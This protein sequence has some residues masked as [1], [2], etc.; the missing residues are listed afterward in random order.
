[1]K[2]LLS[3]SILLF[4]FSCKKSVDVPNPAFDVTVE[5]NTFRV[6]DTIEFKFTGSANIITFYSGEP[7][8]EYQFRERFE[9]DGKPQM[10]FTSYSQFG[11]QSNSLR[12]MVSSDFKNVFDTETLN[13]ATWT[14]ITSRA[15]LSTGTDNTP[16]GV[17]DLSDFVRKDTPI[18]IAFK[19]IAKKLP[20][21]QPTWTI[22]NV[23]VEN[24][25]ADG[26]LVSIAKSADI[27]WGAINVLNPAKAWTVTAAQAQ[28][29]GGPIDTDDNEDWI[30]SKPLSLTRVQRSLGVN[31]KNNPTALQTKYIFTGYTAPGTYT[32]TFEAINANK[33]DSKKII[34]EIIITVQ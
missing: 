27:S 6:K 9:V 31:V 19:Y 26:S 22:K 15:V 25:L 10:Q 7:G 1:M 14:D 33:W 28:M 16:S 24:K 18:Y 8:K 29:S 4:F 20:V 5:K 13:L 21:S 17:I 30:I 12:L 3:I 2:Y 34:K 32:V 11:P 23:L